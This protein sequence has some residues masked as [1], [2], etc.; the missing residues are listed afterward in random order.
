[1]NS[2]FFSQG[3]NAGKEQTFA[4]PGIVLGKFPL[5]HRLGLTVGGG[6]Q[7]AVTQFHTYDHRAIL[8]VRL[9]F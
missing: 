4:T 8:T 3:P 6:I 7:I 1:M 5:W 2:T 9:P